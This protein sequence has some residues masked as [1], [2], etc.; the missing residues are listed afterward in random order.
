VQAELGAIADRHPGLKLII[1]H[2]G[3]MARCVNDAIRRFLKE[4][5][6]A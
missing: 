6:T 3:I 4:V 2:M 5:A 1:D